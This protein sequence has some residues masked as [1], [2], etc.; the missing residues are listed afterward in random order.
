[1]D[2]GWFGKRDNDRCSLGD[3]V[4]DE[5]KLPGGIQG[6]TDKMKSLGIQFGLWVEPEMVSPDSDL[7]RAHPDWCLHVPQRE[8]SQGRQQL[9][10]DLSRTMSA[11]T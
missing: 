11:I 6:I 10:L 7:F 1:M 3:W 9:V 4:V 8:S 5:R 2:D